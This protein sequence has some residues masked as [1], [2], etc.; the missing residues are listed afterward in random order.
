MLISIVPLGGALAQQA[1][2]PIP[3]VAPPGPVTHFPTRFDVV[4]A[5]EQFD[6]VLMIIDFP[7]GTWTPP[8]TP[9]GYIYTTV[10]E[11][12]MSSRMVGVPGEEATYPA[13]ATFFETPGEYMEVGNASSASARVMATALLPKGAPLT[14]NREGESIDAYPALTDRLV[15]PPGVATIHRSSIEVDRPTGAFE[16]VQLLLD[17]SPGISTPKH[18]HGGQELAMVTTGEMTLQRSGDIEIFRAGES[19]VNTTGLVHAAGND[20]I[21]F[22]QAV[23]TFILPAGRP[24]TTVM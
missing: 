2:T 8:H 1:P 15:G 3:L 7:A 18:M 14:I 5:P 19:W 9:G 13:G 10:I 17:F 11:G 23:A 24:L 6:Q 12:E 16:L 4:D 21:D 20:G 22:A